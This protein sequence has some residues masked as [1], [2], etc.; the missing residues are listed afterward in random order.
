MVQFSFEEKVAI[1]TGG[2]TG[3]GLAISGM[4]VRAGA[5]VAITYVNE[6]DSVPRAGS[7]L[8]KEPH[9][10]FALIRSDAADREATRTLV[11]AVEDKWH[12]PVSHIV[13]N[14]GILK[15]GDFFDITDRQWETTMR[16]NL[17]GP[18]ILCQEIMRDMA[19]NGSIV[20]IASIGGQIGG[21][22][23]PDYAASKAGLISLT[24]SLARIGSRSGVRV[25]AVSPGWIET[26]IFSKPR[27]EELRE[28][29]KEVIPLGRMGTPEEVASTVLFLLSDAASYVTGHCLN[30]N[31]GLFFG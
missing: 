22:K 16:N 7:I 1:V 3:I 23:A 31:G 10:E 18:F 4:L 11:R 28:Q 20:N 12:A 15:Q 9:G 27:L 2:T 13:N 19:P 6:D 29:A 24:R 21:D 8:G 25:N 5:R 14:A 30:V 17:M 26:P